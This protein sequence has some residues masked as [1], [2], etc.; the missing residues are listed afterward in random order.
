MFT[1][2]ITHQGVVE[3]VQ[4]GVSGKSFLISSDFPYD[5]LELGASVC[6]AGACLTITHK[7]PTANGSRFG[8]DVSPETLA[9]THLG[10]WQVG[11]RMNLERS[12]R[13]G[14]EL[15]GH[16]VS[17]H[18][19]QL[20]RVERVSHQDEWLVL[21]VSTD[22]KLA[23]LIATKGSIA[24]D[25]VSLTVN[26]VYDNFQSELAPLDS[27]SRDSPASELVAF[28]VMIIPH[29]QEITTLGV[30]KPGD[31]VN[32]EADLM[33]RYAARILKTQR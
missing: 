17:G 32:L 30:V 15:G 6:H 28:S 10:D 19:D 31:R 24:I 33:A 26:A 23:P 14:Q 29:T 2:I 5:E 20:G 3:Q 12:L 13:L 16:W 4:T 25:G 27:V 1:G 22:A 8:V 9:L 7:E 11:T 21:Q 18:I